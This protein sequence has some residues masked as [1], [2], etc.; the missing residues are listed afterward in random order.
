MLEAYTTNIYLLVTSACL[1]VETSATRLLHPHVQSPPLLPPAPI[2]LL[3]HRFALRP[4]TICCQVRALGALNP[5]H[6]THELSPFEA[7]VLLVWNKF[8]FE[9][10]KITYPAITRQLKII[11]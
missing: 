10:V 9:V 4:G 2:R 7:L 6:V 11:I 3:L 5:F 8:V 1:R